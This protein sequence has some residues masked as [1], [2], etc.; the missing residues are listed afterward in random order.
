VLFPTSEIVGLTGGILLLILGERF[1]FADPVP[2][3]ACFG[4]IGGVPTGA[5]LLKYSHSDVHPPGWRPGQRCQCAWRPS[6]AFFSP[7]LWI[8]NF[9]R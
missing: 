1:Q 3:P 9:M 7:G 4:L 2:D 5:W 6:S 8:L